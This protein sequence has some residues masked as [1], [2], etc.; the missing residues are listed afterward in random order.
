MPALVDARRPG[1]YD[2][3]MAQ[4]KGNGPVQA[5]ASSDLLLLL[6]SRLQRAG[7]PVKAASMQAYMKSTLPCHGVPMTAMRGICKELFASLHFESAAQWRA[8]VLSLWRQAQFREERYA[9][10]ELVESR[11]AR[12][13]EDLDALPM[14]EEMI[15]TGAWWDYVD[16]LATHRLSALL[17]KQPATVAQLMRK[18]SRSDDLWKR[19]SAILCQIP[20]KNQT[21]EKL[22]ADC[23][24]QAMDSREFFLR[25]AIGWALRQYAD[26][27]PQWVIDYVQAHAAKLSPLSKR[28]ALRKVQ[29]PSASA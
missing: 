18:W 9:A 7:D 26:T 5:N 19:R 13:F 15:V 2:A 23:I 25:K 1:R 28:E 12:A 14:Y 20:L 6:R 29:R 8:S 11:L 3:P 24:A 16:V 27:S 22:L 21:D 17:K 10:I 4:E